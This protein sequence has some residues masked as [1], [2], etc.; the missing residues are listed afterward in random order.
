MSALNDRLVQYQILASDARSTNDPEMMRD[1]EHYDLPYPPGVHKEAHSPIEGTSQV[2]GSNKRSATGPVNILRSPIIGSLDPDGYSWQRSKHA[3][4]PI[5]CAR[6]GVGVDRK[7]RSRLTASVGATL[8]CQL[9]NYVGLV[10]DYN[11]FQHC[12]AL[13]GVSVFAAAAIY[14]NS[15]ISDIGFLF[16]IVMTPNAIRVVDKIR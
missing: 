1:A 2:V 13:N 12:T 9:S 4:N 7:I 14:V 11:D 10:A 15:F 16:N 8:L 6:H 5:L 3:P